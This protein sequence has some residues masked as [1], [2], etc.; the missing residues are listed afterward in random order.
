[1][2]N[3]AIFK[4]SYF[5]LIPIMK[6]HYEIVKFARWKVSNLEFQRPLI[7]PLFLSSVIVYANSQLW[8]LI[9]LKNGTF[10]N[11]KIMLTT[12]STLKERFYQ[13]SKK[14]YQTL[15]TQVLL[16]N[17]NKQDLYRPVVP[18]L[19]L[20]HVHTRYIVCYH[21]VYPSHVHMF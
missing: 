4:V 20:S 8:R 9:T 3:F 15:Y 5:L 19:Q 6:F 7:V 17:N 10:K 21:N 2:L 13:I 18:F 16:L 14:S 11:S 12:C 1:M